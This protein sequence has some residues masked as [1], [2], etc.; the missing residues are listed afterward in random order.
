MFPTSVKNCFA[1]FVRFRKEIRKKNLEIRKKFTPW[2]YIDLRIT[3][4]YLPHVRP[5]IF[6]FNAIYF[7]INLLFQ[8]YTLIFYKDSH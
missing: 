5:I 8:N 4:E 1:S 6:P 2:I 3:F 7:L